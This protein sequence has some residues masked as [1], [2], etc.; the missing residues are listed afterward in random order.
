V[1]V[2]AALT[3][4]AIAIVMIAIILSFGFVSSWSLSVALDREVRA[5][6]LRAERQ[7]RAAEDEAWSAFMEAHR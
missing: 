2:A 5:G 6:R 4:I 7:R 3:D 1:I